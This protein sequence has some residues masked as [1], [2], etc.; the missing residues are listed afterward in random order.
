MSLQTLS[1]NQRVIEELRIKIAKQ[2]GIAKIPKGN[3]LWTE[4]KKLALEQT[5]D[6]DSADKIAL[7]DMLQA[8]M[9]LLMSG[10][11]AKDIRKELKLNALRGIV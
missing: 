6:W 11:D 8:S 4:I 3:A 10:I 1:V 7:A 5:S 9:P 2:T